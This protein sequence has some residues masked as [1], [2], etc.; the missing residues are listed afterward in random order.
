MLIK[1][2]FGHHGFGIEI[3]KWINSTA[4]LNNLWYV[5]H[6]HEI[7]NYYVGVIKFYVGDS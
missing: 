5:S 7:R 2:R 3:T 1:Q 4:H 6:T